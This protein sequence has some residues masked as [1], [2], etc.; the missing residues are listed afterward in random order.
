MASRLPVIDDDLYVRPL[1]CRAGFFEQNARLIF[2][3]RTA[4]P[5]DRPGL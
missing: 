1:G 5:L 3:P 2:L 4:Q